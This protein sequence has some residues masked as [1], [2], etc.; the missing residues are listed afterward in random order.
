MCPAAIQVA[1][2][3]RPTAAN[4]PAPVDGRDRAADERLDGRRAGFRE[5]GWAVLRGVD[6]ALDGVL[7]RLAPAP[8]EPAADRGLGAEPDER[9]RVAAEDGRV[10]IAPA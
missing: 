10:A 6:R 7:D 2:I 5:V 9:A 4:A 3:P 8:P 1:R